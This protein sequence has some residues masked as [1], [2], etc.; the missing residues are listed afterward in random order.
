MEKRYGADFVVKH[1]WEHRD[2]LQR[3]QWVS[4]IVVITL[5]LMTSSA[6]AQLT[7]EIIGGAGAA[8]PISIVPFVGEADFPL[9]ISGVVGGDLTRSG[10]FRQIDGASII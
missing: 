10:R 9:G 3:L 4:G 8:L 6:R 7:I 1:F 2:F 5:L